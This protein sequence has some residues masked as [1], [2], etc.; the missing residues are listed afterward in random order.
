[1]ADH[2][3]VGAH[4]ATVSTVVLEVSP[5]DSDEVPGANDITSALSAFAAFS[6]ESRVRGRLE[7][8]RRHRLAAERAGPSGSAGEHLDERVRAVEERGELVALL[9]SVLRKWLI[10]LLQVRCRRRP[11]RRS[12]RRAP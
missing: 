10:G 6:K 12:R 2:Q 8:H 1:M 4:R 11:P 7:E 5:F 3:G 9:S